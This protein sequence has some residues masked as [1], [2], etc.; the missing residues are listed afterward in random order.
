MHF[1]KTHHFTEISW[2]FPLIFE[3]SEHLMALFTIYSSSAGSGKTFTL[4][5]EYLR[6]A[7]SPEDPSYFRNILAMT[8]TN[9]AAEEMKRRIISALKGLSSGSS[10]E[11][12]L[13]QLLLEDL[14]HISKETLQQRAGA[15]LHL[16][17]QNYNDF[18]IKTIDSFVNQV[19]S[20]FTFDLNLPYNYEIILDTDELIEEAVSNLTDRVG[21]DEELTEM[22][23]EFALSK[24]DE[25]Q[26]WNSLR[27]DI[28]DFAGVIYQN[29]NAAEIEKNTGLTH[30]DI[31]EIRGRIR[32]YL[33]ETEHA[34]TDLAR[35]ALNLI[36]AGGLSASDFLQGTRGIWNFYNKLAQAP[37]KLWD[38]S[39]P[40]VAQTTLL[41]DRWYKDKS[42]SAPQVDAILPRLRELTRA[43]LA[44]DTD[45]YPTLKT[46]NKNLLKIP[47]LAAIKRETDTLLAGNNEAVLADFN[48]K[49]L[50]IVAR[51]PVPYIYERI[52]ERYNHILVDEFQDTSDIQFFNLLPLFENAVSKNQENLIVGD[53][54]QA[55]YSWRG[56]NVM[57]MLDLVNRRKDYFQ[58][59]APEI[60][61]SQITHIQAATGLKTL[62]TNYRSRAELIAFNNELFSSI[63][64]SQ[65]SEI[66][67]Q[68]FS[69]YLQQTPA[70]PKTGGYTAVEILRKGEDEVAGKITA[71]VEEILADGYRLS[72]ICIL[73]R[74]RKE[75][76][77][78]ASILKSAGYAISSTEALKLNNHREVRFLVSA[79]RFALHPERQFERFEFLQFFFLV[80]HIDPSTFDLQAACALPPAGFTTFFTPFGID[81][82]G[83]AGLDPYQ[84]SEF[85]T[86]K[87]ALMEKS[88]SAEY[89]LTF[90]D[91]ALDYSTRRSKSLADF[92][93]DWEIRKEK[94]A[95]PAR[96]ANA[97]TIN[98]IHKAKGLEYPIVI[99]PF[100]NWE[101][102]PKNSAQIW[103][104]IEALDYPELESSS[105]RIRSAPFPYT[106]DPE[107]ASGILQR[108][109]DLIYIENLNMLY[110]ALTRAID[111][112]YLWIWGRQ[113]QKSFTI[114]HIGQLLEQF[115]RTRS[116]FRP[117]RSLYEFGHKTSP[118][119][120]E[121]QTTLPRFE[122]RLPQPFKGKP[123]LRI[124]WTAP[125]ERVREGN[126]IH[127]AFERI[128]K[129][130][131]L[132][133][134]LKSLQEEGLLP[135]ELAE[136]VSQK[137]RAVLQ[138]PELAPLFEKNAVVKN[139][140]DILSSH[141]TTRRPDRVVFLNGRVYILDYKTGKKRSAHE[142][143][144]QDYARLLLQMGYAAVHLFLVYLDPLEVMKVT[145]PG[146]K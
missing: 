33:K 57:L 36:H 13:Q 1:L 8:F 140:A 65:E 141:S 137:I 86:A 67:R 117:D 122:V 10:G 6:L 121:D 133:P 138:H 95:I 146:N 129:A 124:R 70:N 132:L 22:F 45:K 92:L 87:F 52:G 114:E 74:R 82:E 88:G 43:I 135:E 9:D 71:Q 39:T 14:P 20:S 12:T 5:R 143:Q 47:F 128:R 104:S 139:E 25:N 3:L 145:A 42:P 80:K 97:I 44:F 131:D 18:A 59:K 28:V 106:R 94:L 19:I 35:E 125:E 30:R 99:L 126:L 69:D 50:E 107:F 78:I 40:G 31:L 55:I 112:Q 15:V 79:L 123:G 24:L 100:I 68:V 62:S 61:L 102:T 130:E 105:G 53:P 85:F 142:R 4:T 136:A 108:E 98:T 21:D 23:K 63:T 51:E 16:V 90:L 81:L 60:Q 48:R 91:H 34:V 58:I 41:E 46:I 134:V 76:E 120:K 111:R 29:N 110:V 7:L 26:S 127:T 77:E 144:L 64:G 115:L 73:C 119:H 101:T 103:L 54:K 89:I 109:R 66:A 72:D 38:N 32:T 118:V 116:D 2:H 83:M 11:D 37:A 93:Q 75:G 27:N 56:G 96:A 17:L 49:I 84:L 113:T